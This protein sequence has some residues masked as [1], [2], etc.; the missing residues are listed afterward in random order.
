MVQKTGRLLFRLRLVYDWLLY[1]HLVA[2]VSSFAIDGERFFPG[3][4]DYPDSDI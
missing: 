3:T 2:T 1:C 4:S